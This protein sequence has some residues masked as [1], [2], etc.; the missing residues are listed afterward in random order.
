M[1]RSIG[2]PTPSTLVPLT[3]FST[4]GDMTY[5]ECLKHLHQ[6]R[7]TERWPNDEQALAQLDRDIKAFR[8]QYGSASSGDPLHQLTTE[9]RDQ[10]Q[11]TDDD[12]TGLMLERL[13]RLLLRRQG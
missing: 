2:V 5:D 1:A 7:D 3:E 12:R 6:L 11:G 9:F 4:L 13:E 8:A 10:A